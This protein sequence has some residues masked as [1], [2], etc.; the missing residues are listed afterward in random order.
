[1]SWKAPTL[2]NIVYLPKDSSLWAGSTPDHAIVL[3]EHADQNKP[4]F[5]REALFKVLSRQGHDFAKLGEDP[6]SIDIEGK[7]FTFLLFSQDS[8]VFERQTLLAKAC[9]AILAEHPKKILITSVSSAAELFF[10]EALYTVLVN[11]VPLPSRKKETPGA[12][13]EIILTCMQSDVLHFAK[14][15]A[16]GNLTARSIAVL[17]SNESDTKAMRQIVADIASERGFELEVFD[18]K[19]L[20]DLGA[21]AFLAVARGAHNPHSAIVRLS[22]RK[23]EKKHFALVGKGICFDTGG[24]NLKSAKYMQHMHEDKT[25]AAVV[26]GILVAM[27]TLNWPF[28]VD[29]WLALT[30]NEISPDAYRPHEV[31]KALD[32]TTIEVMHTDAEGRMVLADTLVLAAKQKPD[33]IVDYAT[34]TGACMVALGT[35][36]SGLF[37]ND[38]LLLQAFIEKA[39]TSGERLWPF[40][41]DQDYDRLLESKIADI[42]QCTLDGE[43]DHILAARFLGRFVGS[44]PWMHMDLSASHT[45]DGLGAIV[46]EVTG[47][48]VKA[49]MGFLKSMV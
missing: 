3:L 40:P 30:Q 4:F 18:E 45:K 49:T 28:S 20:N 37:G 6:L 48:G 24:Y 26:L 38:L 13:E 5:G 36:Y 43:A 39:K 23:G 33:F 35:G 9:K 44:V 47:F 8:S 1:M 10:E 46:D 17:P 19:K 12:L 14:A 2:P 22:Y 15:C 7:L 11:A 21:G 32:G 27:D 42:K 25:G 41:Y 31:V 34:L 16:L 29:A